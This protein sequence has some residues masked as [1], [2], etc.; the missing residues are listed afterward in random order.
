[1]K[2][3]PAFDPPEYLEWKPDSAL[4]Q[5]FRSRVSSDPDRSAVI[6]HLS[7]EDKLELYR[8]L[9]RARLHDIGL[10]RWVRQGVI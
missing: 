9:L 4:L 7:P 1:M 10:K 6:D 8:R 3:Y 5:E 2:R